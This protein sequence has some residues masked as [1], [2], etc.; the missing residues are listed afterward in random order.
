MQQL[1]EC[2][3]QELCVKQT[4]QQLELVNKKLSRLSFQKEKLTEQL[5]SSIGHN[6]EGQKTYEYETWKIEVKTPC[7]YS[8]DKKLY[9]SGKYDIP[10]KFNP[11]KKSI[12]YSI[13]KKLCD[14]FIEDAPQDV[15][16]VLIEL[17]EKRPG[18]ASI[19]IKERV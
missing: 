16:A 10:K 7:V 14:K 19:T 4:I 13:D 18:K 6:H 15:R 12:S 11:I 3:E 9:E 2:G 8:L 5:I 17:I 1:W